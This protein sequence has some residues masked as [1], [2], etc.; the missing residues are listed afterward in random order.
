MGLEIV[1]CISKGV[2]MGCSIVIAFTVAKIF[3]R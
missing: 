2:A 1:D 3:K